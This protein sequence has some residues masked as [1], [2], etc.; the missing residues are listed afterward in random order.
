MNHYELRLLAGSP[1]AVETEDQKIFRLERAKRLMALARQH[2]PQRLA[3]ITL[4]QLSMMAPALAVTRLGLPSSVLVDE[5]RRLAPPV[6][7][8]PHPPLV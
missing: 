8:S 1:L 3:G 6:P 7:P 2:G 5:L 4:E